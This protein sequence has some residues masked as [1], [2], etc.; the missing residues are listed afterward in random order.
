MS[1]T[2]PRLIKDGEAFIVKGG[3]TFVGDEEV[4]VPQLSAVTI[5]GAPGQWEA[6]I[7]DFFFEHN[8][9]NRRYGLRPRNHVM[10]SA[11]ILVDVAD[12]QKPVTIV[13]VYTPPVP[14]TCVVRC[15]EHFQGIPAEKV[16]DDTVI[17]ADLN[18]LEKFG[19][20]LSYAFGQ[21]VEVTKGMTVAEL[22]AR[23]ESL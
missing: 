17:T 21:P 8:M 10:L 15:V 3:K 12:G 20:S 1:V 22:V 5:G 4:T 7:N 23:I 14:K 13:Q 19:A 16:N 18:T 2:T 9:R 6:N 11:G